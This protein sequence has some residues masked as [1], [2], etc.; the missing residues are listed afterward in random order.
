MV[1]T[2]Q[3]RVNSGN[4]DPCGAVHITIG[5]GGNREGL[6]HRYVLTLRKL[7]IRDS[8]GHSVD[9]FSMDA[10]GNV[11]IATVYHYRYKDPQPEWSVFREASFGHG[12]LKVVNSSHA[13]WSWHRNDDDEPVRSDQLWITS[14]KSSGCLAQKQHSL[15]KILMAP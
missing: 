5:D 12:E 1:I 6:A 11:N 3:K 4:P 14:L 13:F 8:I 10:S 9:E 15:R 7:W 2:E